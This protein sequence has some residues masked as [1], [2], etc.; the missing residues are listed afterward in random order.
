MYIGNRINYK[1]SFSTI[2]S[3]S[4]NP[5]YILQYNIIPIHPP[6][7]HYSPQSRLLHMAPC[8]YFNT[9]LSLSCILT[10]SLSTFY[11]LSHGYLH[12]V[13]HQYIIANTY[14]K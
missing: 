3:P 6:S 8:I 7:P 13:P 10:S 11:P 1:S 9:K 2:S 14:D 5:L 12:P 4:H